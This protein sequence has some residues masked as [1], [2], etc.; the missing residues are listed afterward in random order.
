[1]VT[2]E[3]ARSLGLQ[4]HIRPQLD[5]REFEEELDEEFFVHDRVGKKLTM[6][7]TTSLGGCDG[8]QLHEILDEYS[9]VVLDIK[10]LLGPRADTEMQFAFLRV[11]RCV[12][13][14][15]TDTDEV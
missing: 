4:G 12:N 13:S 2:W 7:R 5:Y 8:D 1:M 9:H 6:P 15:D 11:S 3:V 10:W 14:A